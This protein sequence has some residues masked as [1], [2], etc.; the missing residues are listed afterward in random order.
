M[1][2]VPDDSLW[3]I[4]HDY[5]AQDPH[6]ALGDFCE[7]R[8]QLVDALADRTERDWQRTGV[9]SGT[10]AQTLQEILNGLCQR[11]AEHLQRIREALT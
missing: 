5:P 3:A 8:A 7:R 9:L 4:E 11:D 10:G 6:A 2:D 1:L